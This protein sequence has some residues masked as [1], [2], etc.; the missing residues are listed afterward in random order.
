MSIWVNTMT[1]YQKLNSKCL[2][3]QYQNKL[4]IDFVNNNL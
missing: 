3:N 4:K 2:E 1:Y